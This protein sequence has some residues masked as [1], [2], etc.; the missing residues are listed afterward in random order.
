MWLG[1]LTSPSIQAVIHLDN[2]VM[3]LSSPHLG[4]REL[5]PFLKVVFVAQIH[6]GT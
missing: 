1:Y 3:H 4:K 5:S 6:K 2:I